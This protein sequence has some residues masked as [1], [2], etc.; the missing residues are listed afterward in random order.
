MTAE[1]LITLAVAAELLG[2]TYHVLMGRYQRHEYGLPTPAKQTS[3]NTSLY[4]ES[5]FLAYKKMGGKR[6][7]LNNDM[8]QAFIFGREL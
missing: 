3:R 6:K 2:I 1:K 5:E 8:A 4:R 7:G